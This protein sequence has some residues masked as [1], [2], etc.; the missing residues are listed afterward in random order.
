MA[1]IS[2]SGSRSTVGGLSQFATANPD[3]PAVL[4][5][6]LDIVK[7]IIVV[8]VGTIIAG[9][10]A[11]LIAD[12]LLNSGQNYEDNAMAYTVVLIPSM[13]VVEILFFVTAVW[14]GPRKY[15]QSLAALGLRKPTRGVWWLA[16]A[17]GFAG[18][19][20]VYGYDAVSSMIGVK[21]QS[22][23]DQV[24]DNAGPFLV[25]A[26]GAVL[27]APVIEEVFFRGFIF[28][29]LWRR[30]GWVFAALVSSLLFSVA[31]LSIYGLP[32][33]A[34]IG[35]LFAWSYRYTGSVKASVIAHAIINTVTVGV[36]L[37]ASF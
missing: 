35:F 4:W 32:V 22:T 15:R 31:H 25:V 11:A 12:S 36:G 16:G 33:F 6:T 8:V 20:L 9:I 24:F 1:S 26:V 21:S 2:V 27:L 17:M 18:V 10:P 29:A 7:A 13:V 5:S 3:R 28:G 30:R 23:P 37:M 14:F 19:G 34:A